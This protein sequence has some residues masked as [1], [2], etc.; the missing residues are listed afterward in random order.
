MIKPA[1]PIGS[2]V[3][4]EEERKSTTTL[5]PLEPQHSSSAWHRL[6]EKWDEIQVG[7]Q[8]A[9]SIERLESFDNGCAVGVSVTAAAVGWVVCKLGVLDSA[10]LNGVHANIADTFVYCSRTWPWQEYIR[11]IR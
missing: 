3:S 5:K 10:D 9:Y 4:H 7:R 8:G 11:S 2:W 6:E 1:T